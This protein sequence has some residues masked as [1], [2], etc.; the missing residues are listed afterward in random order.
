M[1]NKTSPGGRGQNKIKKVSIFFQKGVFKGGHNVAKG[2]TKKLCPPLNKSP[3]TP[4]DKAYSG[5][6][7]WEGLKLFSLK[8]G[9]IGD[10]FLLCTWDEKI[11]SKHAA[12]PFSILMPIMYEM[13]SLNERI[14][15]LRFG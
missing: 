8:G 3:R 6:C 9:A 11:F 7:P 13:Q 14:L 2:G 15:D 12:R 5:I 1:V 10:G 4:L